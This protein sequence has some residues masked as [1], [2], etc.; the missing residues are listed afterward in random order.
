MITERTAVVND[1]T[2]R[3]LHG[4]PDGRPIV[5]FVHEGGFGGCA[6]VSWG[7][8]LPLAAESYRVI[9]PD[10]LGF[11]G[12]AKI[13]RF[14]EP[15]FGFRLRH[16]YA[17]LDSLGID[18]QV[19]LVGHCFGGS[20]ILRALTDPALRARIATA[21]VV[22]GTGGPWRTEL[23]SELGTYD[24][25]IQSMRRIEELSCGTF[26]GFEEYIETRQRWASVPGHFSALASARTPV[27]EPLRAA[28]PADPYPQ[29]L[30]GITTPL[31]LIEGSDD[32]LLEPGWTKHFVQVLPHTTVTTLP[33]KHSPNI[34][35]PERTWQVIEQ[36]IGG[37]DVQ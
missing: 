15:P 21:S 24:G 13:T 11:G 35:H 5:V 34:S 23:T 36:F 19:H 9:A 8:V 31:L 18:G 14:D 22:S 12:T 32:A 6:D 37:T 25:T 33:A 28:R 20:V 7:S 10:M 29:T 1:L 27:P 30:A 3:Y 4:G 17:L 26:P 16:I 2:T